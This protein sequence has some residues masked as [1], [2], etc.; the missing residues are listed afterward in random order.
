MGTIA[1]KHT[2]QAGTTI[3]SAQVNENFDDIYNEF[4]GNITNA[5][6]N[7]SAAIADSKLAQ[8]T[9]AGKE[10]ASA[11][12]GFIASISQDV[13][14][15]LV[16]VSTLATDA[17]IATIFTITLTADRT[18]GDPTN[19]VAG[20]KRAWRFKQDSTGFW[21]VTLGADFRIPTDIASV[22]QVITIERDADNY[23]YMGAIYNGTD[24][25]WD[26]VAVT[27]GIS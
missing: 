9:T 26:V 4:N 20:M 5:N 18:L 14:S 24:S 15:A 17:A 8:I 27:K 13:V 23:T 7:G 10:S 22:G 19:S 25:K 12:T 1:K 2:F 16:D 6:I 3:L 11:I 21:E